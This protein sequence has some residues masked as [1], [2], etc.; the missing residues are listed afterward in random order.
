MTATLNYE[1]IQ[2]IEEDEAH[3]QL[4]D[5]LDDQGLAATAWQEFAVAPIIVHTGAEIRSKGSKIA[6]QLKEAFMSGTARKEALTRT[7][8]GFFANI[9]EPAV[10]AQHLVT[11][12]CAATE[13]PHSIDVGALVISHENGR[14]FRNVAGNSIT[15]PVTLASGG[16]QTLLFE[17]EVAGA[18]GTVLDS[19]TPATVTLA[20]VTTLSGVSITSH[21]LERSGQDEESDDRLDER[22]TLRWTERSVSKSDDGIKQRA[23]SVAPGIVSV[24][25]DSTNPRGP[26]TTDVYIAGLDSTAS[27]DEVANVQIALDL[28][29]FG[30][31]AS[32]KTIKVY[33]APEVPLDVAGTTYF[34]GI[35]VTTAQAAVAAG[36]LTFVRDTPPGGYDFSPGP[37]G[38]VRVNDIE[39]AIKNAL[40]AAGAT[41]ATVSVTTPSADVA[42]SFYDK[43]VQGSYSGIAYVV[44]S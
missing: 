21:A 15:Y 41:T 43:V 42:L 17:A 26:G 6:V 32:P 27:A 12:A 25:V 10:E 31:K 44:L 11:L 20:L 19:L 39:T 16:T 18:D 40:I 30:R 38:V 34:Q 28:A 4:L 37:S 36:L 2:E 35:D 14:T 24:A 3:Q 7:A 9:R 33:A 29:T 23:V 5:L 8:S 1:D 22:N 13:G